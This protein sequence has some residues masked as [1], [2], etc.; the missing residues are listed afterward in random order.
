MDLLLR[1]IAELR[2]RFPGINGVVVG[3]G[4]Q[5]DRLKK[6]AAELGLTG[7]VRFTGGI[8]EP[9]DLG[10]EMLGAGVYVLAGMGG[11]SINEAMCFGLPVV[12]SVCDGTE[13]FLVRDGKTGL[14][15]SDGDLP[16]LCDKIADLLGDPNRAAE[17]GSQ[18]TELIRT[19]VNIHTVTQCYVGLLRGLVTS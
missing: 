18:A 16:D 13:L 17:M 9:L 14:R 8:Y 12:C 1:A 10:R 11:L 6:L 19:E 5:E 3:T 15:F 4:P 7:I 2:P